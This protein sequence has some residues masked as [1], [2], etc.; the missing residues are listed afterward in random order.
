MGEGDEEK[1]LAQTR[2]ILRAIPVR[3]KSAQTLATSNG[4]IISQAKLRLGHFKQSE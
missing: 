1:A 4:T 2:R 3:K